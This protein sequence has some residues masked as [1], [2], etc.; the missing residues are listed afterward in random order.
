MV[1][2]D[3]KTSYDSSRW[4]HTRSLPQDLKLQS[5]AFPAWVKRSVFANPADVVADYLGSDRSLQSPWAVALSEATLVPVPMESE[6]AE[7]ETPVRPTRSRAANK[8]KSKPGKRRRPAEADLTKPEI[9]T[10]PQ[11]AE[12][13]AHAAGK[14][15][16][17]AADV[18]ACGRPESVFLRESRVR[19]SGLTSSAPSQR[20]HASWKNA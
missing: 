11:T 9:K 15:A 16:G 10:D 8:S 14:V 17:G 20:N 13:V 12:L 18:Q 4:V 5:V 7:E 19:M 6:D 1:P 3:G 2:E